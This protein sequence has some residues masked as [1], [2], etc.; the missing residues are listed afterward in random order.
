MTNSRNYNTQGKYKEN[1]TAEIKEKIL[2]GA[3]M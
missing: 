1:H 3:K 2:K